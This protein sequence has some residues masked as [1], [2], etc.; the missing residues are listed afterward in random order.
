MDHRIPALAK[1]QLGDQSESQVEHR[2][3]LQQA[4]E[5]FPGV[6]VDEDR[7]I[8]VWHDRSAPQAQETR[9]QGPS[10]A[11]VFSNLKFVNYML[12]NDAS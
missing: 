3:I 7:P 9:V 2:R 11:G 1:L 4:R 5:L 10:F 12:S 8:N 6:H